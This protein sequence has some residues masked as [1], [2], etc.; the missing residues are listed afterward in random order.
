MIHEKVFTCSYKESSNAHARSCILVA[1]RRDIV[2]LEARCLCL[3]VQL[4]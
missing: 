3:E 2:S 4:F 1:A